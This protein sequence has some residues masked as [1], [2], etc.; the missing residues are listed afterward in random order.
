MKEEKL[1][2]IAILIDINIK[3]INTSV[4][5]TFLTYRSFQIVT[6]GYMYFI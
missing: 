4:F 2:E 5:I 3:N 1:E 6:L